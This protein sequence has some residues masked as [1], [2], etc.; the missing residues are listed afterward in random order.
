MK[1]AKIG[2]LARSSA[3]R[4]FVVAMYLL[5]IPGAAGVPLK[6]KFR[7]GKAAFIAVFAAAE[8]R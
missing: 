5:R 7:C 3:L 4:E 8:G 1:L 6:Y 2:L